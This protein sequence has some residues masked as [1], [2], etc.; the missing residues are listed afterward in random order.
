MY[1]GLWRSDDKRKIPK[2]LRDKRDPVL[3]CSSQITRGMGWNYSGF[4]ADK[5]ELG[6]V[7]HRVVRVFPFGYHSHHCSI[8]T[9]FSQ[10]LLTTN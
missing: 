4:V 5:V 6:Q 7:F 9:Q 2:Y 3:P 1:A 10:L 8:Q